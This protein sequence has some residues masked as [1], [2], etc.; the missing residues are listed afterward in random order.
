MQSAVDPHLH[1]PYRSV[2]QN[3]FEQL[4]LFIA[5]FISKPVKIFGF[6]SVLEPIVSTVNSIRSHGP[7]N[8]R[9]FQTFLLEIGSEYNGLPNTLQFDGSAV[10]GFVTIFGT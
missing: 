4:W 10:E 7:Y 6:V 2:R 9:Q 5:F 3:V 1:K 8:H